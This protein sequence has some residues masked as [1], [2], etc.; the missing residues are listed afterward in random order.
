MEAKRDGNYVTTLIATSNADGV[1]P[2]NVSADPIGHSLDVSDGTT[3]SDLSENTASRDQN[4]V[5]VIMAVSSA[6]GVT[7][8]AVYVDSV[9]NKL[10][11]D[12]T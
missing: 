6:D 2:L 11:V 7:P 8:V 4:Y 9:T 12:S 1:T 5:P 3:G 10:L